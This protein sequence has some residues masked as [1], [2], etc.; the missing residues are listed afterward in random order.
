MLA[1]PLLLLALGPILPLSPA[2]PLPPTG[3]APGAALP[4]ADGAAEAEGRGEVAPADEIVVTGPRLGRPPEELPYRVMEIEG[5]GPHADTI[6]AEIGDALADEPAISVQRTARGQVSPFSRGQTGFRVLTLIDG[7]RL[8]QAVYRDGPNQYLS[9]VDPW[10]LGSARVVHGPGSVLYG[11]DAVGGTI[12]LESRVAELSS[13]GTIAESRYVGRY[14]SAE[15]SI[16]N[17]VESELSTPDFAV[18]AGGT[19]RDFDDL[20][21][22]RHVGLQPNT[23]HNEWNGDI[24]IAAPLSDTVRVTGMLQAHEQLDVPRTH[25]TI[26]G[27]S[28]RG[29]TVGTDLQRDLDQERALE[30]LRFDWDPEEERSVELLL[31]RHRLSETEERTRS[32]GRQQIQELD[33]IAWG[34]S[35]SWSEETGIGRVSAGVDAVLEDVDSDGIEYTSA[36]AIFSDGSRGAVA[37]DSSYDT[38]GVYIEDEI[39]LAEES[40]L[41]LGARFTNVAVEADDVDPNPADA[42]VIAPIDESWSDVVG[43]VRLR[44]RV[45]EGASAFAGVSQAFRAPNL[46]DLTR[47][48]SAR[49]GEFE[50]PEPDLDPERFLTFELGGDWERG[51][52]RTSGSVWYTI[53]DGL[54]VRYPTGATT[55][56]GEAIVSKENAG[57]GYTAGFEVGVDVEITRE[58]LAGGSFAWMEG[59]VEQTVSPGVEKDEPL[60]KSP[61]ARGELH[62]RFTPEAVPQVTAEARVRIADEMTRLSE[63][64][65]ADTQR[66]PPGGTPGYA[67]LDLRLAWQATDRLRL[68][69][70][71]ENVTDRDY[72]IHGSGSNELGTNVAL[73]VELVF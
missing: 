16:A 9:L 48:D 26:Y 14:A 56:G 33:D 7:V 21:G 25:A 4:P 46:S 3:L 27:I 5:V 35:L 65:E 50:V 71:A 42:N 30:W 45:A 61:P 29:T 18:R 23:A 52:V 20:S 47:F 49:T 38:Y 69:L 57:D 60:S 28:W 53:L 8:N 70:E 72:R 62:L 2:L 43:S 66:I 19:Y 11:S 67:V 51:R 10:M 55:A 73:G 24:S 54:I 22:G 64:D 44:Q 1:L 68:M 39:P 58:W 36:G 40:W 41:T 31:S 17:R 6:P 37:D 15:A 32:N 63:S 34:A 59:L 12:L 13:I